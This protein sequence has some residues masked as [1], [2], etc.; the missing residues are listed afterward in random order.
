MSKQQSTGMLNTDQWA[1]LANFARFGVETKNESIG[2]ATTTVFEWLSRGRNIALDH[3]IAT[4][5]STISCEKLTWTDEEAEKLAE[6]FQ[7]ILA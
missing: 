5:L 3:P 1:V 7:D 2:Y 4:L 6:R